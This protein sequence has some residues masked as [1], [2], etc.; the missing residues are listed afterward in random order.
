MAGSVLRILVISLSGIVRSMNNPDIGKLLSS[1]LD[2]L[3]K[4]DA[5]LLIRGASERSIT[6]VLAEHIQDILGE[7]GERYD[8]DCEY[9]LDIDGANGK[10]EIVL[11]RQELQTHGLLTTTVETEL[12]KALIEKAVFP[13][14]IVHRRKTNKN[15]LL[16]IE[17]KKSTSAI[18][19]TYDQLKVSAYTARRDGNHLDYQLGALVLIHIGP[20][21]D[22]QDRFTVTWYVD[23]KNV[24]YLI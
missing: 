17:A 19:Q 4:A 21:R 12:E 8:V 20:L 18:N 15:N 16:I 7:T 9:N 5:D 22:G 2:R 23:G 1:A 13:D 11:L 3:V 14:I 10:K 6:H 24:P